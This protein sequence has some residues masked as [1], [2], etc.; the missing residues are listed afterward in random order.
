MGDRALLNFRIVGI[1]S[2]I[3][4]IASG[5]G[6]RNLKRLRKQYGGRNWRKRKGVAQIEMS[7]GEVRSAELDWY[8]E[9]SV[10]KREVKRKRYLD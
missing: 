10:G 1:I 9:S 8:E 3:E 7:S 2:Q 4:I 5:S 6:I